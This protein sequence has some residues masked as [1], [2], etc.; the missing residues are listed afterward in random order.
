MQG[1]GQNLGPQAKT[2]IAMIYRKALN[3]AP[4]GRRSGMKR[5]VLH[6]RRYGLARREPRV[7]SENLAMFCRFRRAPRAAI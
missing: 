7:F 1:K 2:P 6:R 3:R 5:P 4:N